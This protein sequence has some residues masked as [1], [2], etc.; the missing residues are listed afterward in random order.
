M[1]GLPNTGEAKFLAFFAPAAGEPGDFVATAARARRRFS[2]S[3][4]GLDPN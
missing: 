4:C 1:A 2:R 3:G